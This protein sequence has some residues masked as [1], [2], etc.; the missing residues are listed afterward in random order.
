M[1]CIN[2]KGWCCCCCSCRC[3]CDSAF[4][5]IYLVW[6]VILRCFH[7]ISQSDPKIIKKLM[8]AYRY[9][10]IVCRLAVCIKRKFGIDSTHI[11][12]VTDSRNW[13]TL[14]PPQ[15]T[16]MYSKTNYLSW[17]KHCNLF[18]SHNDNRPLTADCCRLPIE[19]KSILAWVVWPVKW[20]HRKSD[21]V[22]VVYKFN[23][24][25]VRLGVGSVW[26]RLYRNDAS[27]LINH[28]HNLFSSIILF[29][30]DHSVARSTFVFCSTQ[31]KKRTFMW[32]YSYTW[33][34]FHLKIV[35][36]MRMCTNWCTCLLL[37]HWARR[38]LAFRW[39]YTQKSFCRSYCN[40]CRNS[41][42]RRNSIYYT[43]SLSLYFHL[44]L[45]S[46]Y[47][48]LY[49][50]LSCALTNTHSLS[51]QCPQPFFESVLKHTSYLY[52]ASIIN[53]N[54]FSTLRH[55]NEWKAFLMASE[56]PALPHLHTPVDCLQIE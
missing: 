17:T 45:L 36:L 16:Q 18:A 24:G 22:R 26:N 20:L 29:N 15:K 50:S 33:H 13:N 49:L 35:L 40:Y 34:K 39:N 31:T 14:I 1:R 37:Y 38:L 30:R 56:W 52:T 6:H 4:L 32:T 25:A 19:P 46:S 23:S 51:I 8:S 43:F 10:G 27:D 44:S 12:V 21:F 48:F 53:K 2:A 3:W 28:E 41:K 55:P 42:Q 54:K 7:R 47:L 11:Y 5:V 9:V